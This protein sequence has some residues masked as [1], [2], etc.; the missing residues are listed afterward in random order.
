MFSGWGDLEKI[1]RGKFIYL[2]L[3]YDGTLAPIAGRPEKAF[4]PKRTEMLLKE[5]S[6]MPRM[7]IAAVSGRGLKDITKKIGL[8]KVT[9]AGNHGFEIKGP[10][11]KFSRKV[12]RKYKNAVARLKTVL[13]K[14]LSSVEGAFVEDKGLSLSVHYRQVA[15]KY[16]PE[17]RSVLNKALDIPGTRGAVSVTRAKMALEIR[18]P[19]EWDKGKAV[20]WL[21]SRQKAKLKE[22][23]QGIMP[24]YV[25]DDA[26]DEDAFRALDNLGITVS[27]GNRGM[28]SARYFIKDISEVEKFLRKI[29]DH[30]LA[31]SGAYSRTKKRKGI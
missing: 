7:K 26:T 3:D 15:K 30:G 4:T 31:V 1:L 22:R 13:T 20:L 6:A 21:L 10:G 23:K 11:V 5:L 12:P 18:P 28:T 9:Y 16:I 25:G 14:K 24:I 17:V 2:F 19:V 29:R 8:K 27:V